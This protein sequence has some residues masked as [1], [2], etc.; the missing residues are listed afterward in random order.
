M[1]LYFKSTCYHVHFQDTTLS[2]EQLSFKKKKKKKATNFP[3]RGLLPTV[4][5]GRVFK[6]YSNYSHKIKF[7]PNSRA[8]EK[9]MQ[10][11][12]KITDFNKIF[13]TENE[14]FFLNGYLGFPVK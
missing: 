2:K 8:E 14:S 9:H 13:F 3:E 6:K 12:E 5:G 1:N 7:K 10:I 11:N 4:N